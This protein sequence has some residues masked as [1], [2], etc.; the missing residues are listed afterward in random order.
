MTSEHDFISSGMDDYAT[1]S[2]FVRYPYYRIINNASAKIPES[3]VKTNKGSFYNS[4]TGDIKKEMTVIPLVLKKTSAYS[5]GKYPVAN[6]VCWSRDYFYPDSNPPISPTCRRVK[7]T[8]RGKVIEPLCPKAC[9]SSADGKRTPPLCKDSV[10][11]TLKEVG[12]ENIFQIF[13]RGMNLYGNSPLFGFLDHVRSSG[14]E[15][16]CF[17]TVIK[18][19][20]GELF[21]PKVATANLARIV[22]FNDVTYLSNWKDNLELIQQLKDQMATPAP[23]EMDD[24]KQ[25]VVDHLEV[26]GAAY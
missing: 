18:T 12:T 17:S 10:V 22:T 1:S 24:D 2:D 20:S 7:Q 25:H 13:V 14:K 21:F 8:P 4:E 3:L 26:D 9:W 5:E 11:L 23:V 15:I 6:V 19:E 16:Y